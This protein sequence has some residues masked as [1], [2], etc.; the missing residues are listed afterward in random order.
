MKKILYGAVLL[1]FALMTAGCSLDE[2]P[3]S[4]IPESEAYSNPTMVYVNTV[5]NL[6]VQLYKRYNV[7]EDNF[8]YYEDTTS[9]LLWRPGRGGDWVDGGKHQNCHLHNYTPSTDLVKSLWNDM[10]SDIALINKAL[11]KLDEIGQLGVLDEEELVKYKAEVRAI[12]AFYYMHLCNFYGNIPIVTSPEVSVNE[13]AQSPRSKTLE[14]LM[15]EMAFCVE[16]LPNQKAGVLDDPYYG[17]FT[18]GAAY[19]MLA[20]LAINAGVFSKDTW[21]DGTFVGGYA[22]ETAS[23]VTALG[24]SVTFKVDKQEMNAWKTVIYC[25]D[26]LVALGYTLNGS[27]T[28]LF[29]NGNEGNKEAIFVHPYDDN[30]YRFT[31]NNIICSVHYNHASTLGFGSW[32]GV[33]STVRTMNLYGVKEDLSTYPDPGK[34]HSDP[35]SEITITTDDPRFDV[36]FYNGSL[37]LKGV[38]VLSGV[39]AEIWP[40]G[41]YLGSTVIEDF[42]AKSPWEEYLVKWSGYRL[43]KFEFDPATS[44]SNV[45]NA[46]RPIYR[47][48]DILLYA[49]EAQYRL[50]QTEAAQT[51]FNEVRDRAGAPAIANITLKDIL[52]ER[53]R[54]LMWETVGRRSDLIRV[55]EYTEP[56]EDKYVGVAHAS[57]AGDFYVDTDG[58][59]I[60]LPIPATAI[61][62]NSKLNQNPGY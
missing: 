30:A 28:N 53:A 37:S 8:Q 52:D 50:G 55:G 43:K 22:G 2:T 19:A 40:L 32:N 51:L 23:K 21:N 42:Q 1:A 47:M 45:F 10:Y 17:R 25:K 33:C 13:V 60:V 39:S 11:A 27:Y 16:N 38:D 49:A 7:G 35:N 61:E 31:D 36:C 44:G 12:R 18:K 57:A 24:N 29:K 46:D 3:E 6:Y 34:V 56:T 5:A 15:E 4:L 14:F 58:H 41:C 20:Q 62:L 59:T 48:A 9:D 54:E 26:Q